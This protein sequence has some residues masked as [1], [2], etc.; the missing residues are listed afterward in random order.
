MRSSLDSAA[1]F[2]Q[3][4]HQRIKAIRLQTK[5]SVDCHSQKITTGDWLL[6]PLP[7]V[8]GNGLVLRILYN[9]QTVFS[10]KLIADAENFLVGSDDVLVLVIPIQRVGADKDMIVNVASICMRRHHISVLTIRQSGCQFITNL[11]RQLRRNFSRLEGLPD[12]IPDDLAR[13]GSACVRQIGIPQK[14][15]FIGCRLR[16]T[17]MRG[18]QC[19]ALRFSG[20]HDVVQTFLYAFSRRLSLVDMQRNDRCRCHVF[21]QI[22]RKTAICE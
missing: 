14:H 22:Q 12:M 19:A 2:F 5:G 7:L 21:L 3:Q 6:I 9:R 8:I 1:D 13:N 11:V 20:I 18:D 15:E 4:L 10:A 17:R 16:R